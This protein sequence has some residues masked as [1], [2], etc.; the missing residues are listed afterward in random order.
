MSKTSKKPPQLLKGFKD[1]LPEHQAYWD[2]FNVE[3]RKILDSYGY[4]R[5]DLPVLEATNLYIK[6][7]GKHTDIVT[8][9]LY[10][11]EDKGGE[12]VTIRPEFTP[13]IC[14]EIGRAHV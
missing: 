5:I 7:T 10:S 9:E 13:G 4:E 12:N 11:F 8:K 2:F 1:I 14:R 6:G 3:A